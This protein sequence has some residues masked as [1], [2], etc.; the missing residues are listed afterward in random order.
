MAE[1]SGALLAFRNTLADPGLDA[2]DDVTTFTMSD[3]N[4]TLQA[5]GNDAG[6]GSD[7]A[8]GGHHIIDRW[9]TPYFST[10]SRVK[11]WKSSQLAPTSE[12]R[13]QMTSAL[14]EG[15]A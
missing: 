4:R 14:S 3:F 5:N 15:T 8:W 12:C 11:K 7:H 9:G 6:G 1:L 10:R 13:P 2:F